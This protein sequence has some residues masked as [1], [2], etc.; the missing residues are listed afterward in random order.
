[1]WSMRLMLCGMPKMRYY[2]PLL[3][4]MIAAVEYWLAIRAYR[5]SGSIPFT[6]EYDATWIALRNTAK[7][8][9]GIGIGMIPVALFFFGKAMRIW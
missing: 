2:I 8:L 6:K 7:G 5:K 1:M 3:G 4:W 9:L